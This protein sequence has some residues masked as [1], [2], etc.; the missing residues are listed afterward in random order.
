MTLLSKVATFVVGSEAEVSG[1]IR[2]GTDHRKEQPDSRCPVC[3]EGYAGGDASA[4]RVGA[5]AAQ[6]P[7]FG[8]LARR[9][10][11]G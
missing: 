1:L 10:A 11:T 7:Y 5:S 6:A 9:G 8:L 2:T 3:M 4:W